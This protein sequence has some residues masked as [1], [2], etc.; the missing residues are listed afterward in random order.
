MVN[1]S[2]SVSLNS[3]TITAGRVLP[4]LLDMAAGDPE[5]YGGLGTLVGHEMGHALDNQGS[6]YDA[7]G[8][9]RNWWSAQ[10]KREFERRTAR[11]TQQYSRYQ[12]VVGIAL[13]G[14]AELSEN[15]GDL[16]GLSVGYQALKQLR[17]SQQR[18]LTPQ[19]EQRFFQ[20]W[21]TR[22]RVQYT[23]PMLV[24]VLKSDTH[25]PLQYR[26]TVPLS[27]FDPFYKVVGLDRNSPA[28]LA[29]EERV[30]IW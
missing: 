26:C 11:L 27:N 1:G 14:S 30:S 5:N 16:T 3:L 17:K 19:D 7:D 25:P 28:Y 13:N 20:A 22:W 18:P 15:I 10:D 4:P 21:A 9:R 23:E 29:P 8:N 24:R 12:P 2:Y 6:Q